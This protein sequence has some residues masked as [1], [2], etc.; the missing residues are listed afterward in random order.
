[1]K[2]TI[3][4]SDPPLEI[5]RQCGGYYKCPRDTDGKPLGPLVGYAGKDSQGRQYVG[6][7]YAN[8]AKAEEQPGVLKFFAEETSFPL[9]GRVE[10][11]DAFCGAP[12]GGLGFALM[13]AQANSSRYLFAE[14]QVLEAARDSQ[15]EKAMLTFNRHEPLPGENICIV[16]DVCNNFSTTDELC[17]RIFS[18][19]AK[20]IGIVCLLNRSV[21]VDDMFLFKDGAFAAPIPVVSLVR[22]V[23]PQY[24]QDDP[25]VAE[26]VNTGNV[27]WKPK[28][29]WDQLMLAMER[30]Q[31]DLHP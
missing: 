29:R 30:N 8:F 19:G 4:L 2:P 18:K 23:I 31:H 22:Q 15:R 17:G 12:L 6:Y 20:V 3:R 28:D 11:I 9:L 26:Y 27:I 7:E 1:M 16:E 5:L 25:E 14:K 21:D 10:G 24:Q 13:L